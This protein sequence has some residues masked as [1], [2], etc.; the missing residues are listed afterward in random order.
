MLG[1]SLASTRQPPR[2]MTPWERTRIG[3]PHPAQVTEGLWEPSAKA[4]S[5]P[6]PQAGG[7]TD[8]Q[9]EE[10]GLG[11][12]LGHR[13]AQGSA[14]ERQGVLCPRKDLFSRL[15]ARPE[16]EERRSST[17]TGYTPP[18]SPRDLPPCGPGRGRMS[19]L[20]MYI[21]VFI[22]FKVL[23]LALRV[24]KKKALFDDEK[25]RVGGGEEE[26]TRREGV[27]FLGTVR[28]PRRSCHPGDTSSDS[29]PTHV[30][31]LGQGLS[32]PV[33]H[34]RNSLALAPVGSRSETPTTD[35]HV[36]LPPSCHT[37]ILGTGGHL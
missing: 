15:S 18:L 8:S 7:Q 29:S 19:H 30:P 36:W 22:A 20:R 28:R 2:G 34:H 3:S 5:C 12:A 32:W 21:E 4:K 17:L 6:A 10:E 33:T 14:Q 9:K 37:G 11:Q 25:P 16:Q 23:F 31:H 24:V 1:S 13:R 27:R 35:L 26:A